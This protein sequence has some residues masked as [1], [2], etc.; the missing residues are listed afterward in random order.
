MELTTRRNLAYERRWWTLGVLSLSLFIAVVDN[1]II[2]VA[3]PTL[4]REFSAS[5]SQLQWIVD[6][7]ILV[8]AGLLLTAG[9]LGDRF[10][11]RLALMTGLTMFGLGSVAAVFADSAGHLIAVRA[12]MGIGGALIMPSTLSILTNV[13]PEDERPKAIAA[14]SAVAGI[15]IVSGP[16]IGGWLLEHTGWQALFLVNLPV[17]AAALMA[18]PFLVPESK[19]ENRSRLDPVG[20][21]LSIATLTLLLYAIIQ[22]PEAGW[23]S[24]ATLSFFSA[25]AV[26]LVGLVAWELRNPEPMIDIRFFKNPRFSAA[27]LSITLVFFALMGTM[28]YLTQHLQLVLGFSTLE[29]GIRLAPFA[30]AMMFATPL[31]AT[32]TKRYGAKITV[33]LGLTI[34]AA[35]LAW[36]ALTVDVANGYAY[37]VGMMLT[38]GFGMGLAMTPATDAILGALPSEKAGLG[39]AVNDTTREVGAALGVAVLGS[40]LSSAYASSIGNKLDSLPAHLHHQATDSIGGAFAVA[41][42]QD[43]TTA[44]LIIDAARSAFVTGEATGIMVGAVCAFAG[45]L[46]ALAF[47][48]SRAGAPVEDEFVVVGEAVPV[49][50]H[51]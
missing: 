23:L 26:A 49:R 46:L 18:N 22:A 10:G 24:N 39:S 32:M 15:G 36:F 50:I 35:G 27:S 12:V 44:A 20:S 43:S 13:F 11:R 4:V 31:A 6:A 40:L 3:L 45:A 30:V 5:H 38:A 2:N 9:A 34:V 33:A 14:W 29:A 41:A 28:F 7:Y 51:D 8:F 48:P 21:V 19:A 17:I 42:G 25:G 47:L 37:V 16:T 1:T